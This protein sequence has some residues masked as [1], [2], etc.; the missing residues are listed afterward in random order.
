MKKLFMLLTA[1]FFVFAVTVAGAAE[2]KQETGLGTKAAEI[3]KLGGEAKGEKAVTERLEKQFGVDE[4]RIKSLR[5][6]KLG[7]GEIAIALSLAEKLPGGITDGNVDKIMTMRQGP[8]VE[9][10]GN[11]ARKLGVKLGPVVSGVEKVRSETNKEMKRAEREEMQREKKEK[12]EKI[13]KGEKGERPE[14]MERP[15]PHGRPERP[16]TPVHGRR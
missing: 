11:V 6:K 16:E 3:N 9:G 13:E 4:A 15:E 8:P 5:D 1:I 10:W 14:K 7:Y 12:H 2:T